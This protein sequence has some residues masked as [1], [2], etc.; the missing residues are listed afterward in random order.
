VRITL[1]KIS[2]KRRRDSYDNSTTKRGRRDSGGGRNSSLGGGGGLAI[3]G[4]PAVGALDEA[5]RPNSYQQLVV[6]L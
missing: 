5:A 2:P 4:P 3:E 6:L 1:E